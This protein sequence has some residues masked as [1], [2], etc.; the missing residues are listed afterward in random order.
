[1]RKLVILLT[2]FAAL[3]CLVSCNKKEDNKNQESSA[4]MGDTISGEPYGDGVSLPET[5]TFT[6][7]VLSVED[8]RMLVSPDEENSAISPQVYVNTSQF[9]SLEIKKGDKVS[10]VFNGQVAQSFPPQI[11]AVISITKE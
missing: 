9:P 7:Q 5:Y 11:F 4:V 3:F 10:I 1:M 8:G 6:G 2:V